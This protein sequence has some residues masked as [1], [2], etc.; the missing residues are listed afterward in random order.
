MRRVTTSILAAACLGLCLGPKAAG[1]DEFQ[2]D[3]EGQALY[4][5]MVGAM[6]EAK[7]LYYKS[8]YRWE[9]EGRE[10]GHA[11]YQMWLKKPNQFRMEASITYF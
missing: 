11:V 3:P 1:Q 4:D 9:A 6:R 2:G 7:S 8:D 10:L 5:T